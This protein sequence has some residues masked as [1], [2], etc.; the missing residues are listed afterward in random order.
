MN[1]R[2]RFAG[3]LRS[4][5]RLCSPLICV[6]AL[7]ACSSLPDL[8]ESGKIDYKSAAKRSTLEVPPDLVTP[9]T[10]DRGP[11]SARPV[12]ATS[13][14]AGVTPTSAA[15]S[16]VLPTLKGIQFERSGSQRW[17][18]VQLPA[19]RVYNLA[20]DFWIEQGF[21]LEVQSPQTGILETE[22]AENRAKLG[23]DGVRAVLGRIFDSVYSTGERDKFRVRIEPISSGAEVYLTHKG[24]IEVVQ[25]L[26]KETTTWTARPND[27]DL[28]AEFLRRLALKLGADNNQAQNVAVAARASNQPAAA[29]SA[30]SR[31]ADRA[32][33]VGGANDQR[34]EF[35]DKSFDQAWRR[36][37][38]ALDRS[39]FTV[40]DRNRTE[41]IYYVRYADPELEA[42][43]QS[44][45]G[46]LGKL[47]SRD[48]DIKPK[49]FRVSVK[50][51][52]TGS[53]V[54]VLDNQGKALTDKQDIQIGIRMLNLLQAQLR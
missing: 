5:G 29:N 24:M 7:G 52:S 16:G 8:S 14:S 31:E 6:A 20:K 12:T 9:G 50:T 51:S 38:I 21:N 45:R 36:T 25:G 44:D 15:S 17:M 34:L 19:D 46:F 10:V 41:A 11:G 28:E 2:L 43:T 26:T 22:W 37:G 4:L 1:S 39:G 33:V 42:K 35:D 53:V 3:N 47:F 27:P 13:Q 30:V 48:T 49:V 54:T 40:E 18:S 32:R 23:N